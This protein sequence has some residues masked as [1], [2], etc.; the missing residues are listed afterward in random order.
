MEK[1]LSLYSVSTAVCDV[2]GDGAHSLCTFTVGEN[3]E[4]HSE[5]CENIYI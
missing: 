1:I 4:F 2:I 3:A 5:V